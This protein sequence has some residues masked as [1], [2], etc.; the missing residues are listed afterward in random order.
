MSTLPPITPA[1]AWAHPDDEPLQKL[2]DSP[3]PVSNPLLK[4]A[5][6]RMN[7]HSS[8]DPAVVVNGT[9]KFITAGS[10]GT[11]NNETNALSV[12]NGMRLPFS[13]MDNKTSLRQR[14]KPS[15][16]MILPP[17]SS[18][19]EGYLDETIGSN[20]ENANNHS[21]GGDVVIW[22]GTPNNTPSHDSWVLVYGFSS[23][24]QYEEVLCRFDS[25]G[26][27]VSKRGG[28]LNWV[29]LHYESNLEAEKARCQQTC[30]LS[31]GCVVGVSRMDQKLSQ[32]LDWDATPA[33]VEV[34]HGGVPPTAKSGMDEDDVLRKGKAYGNGKNGSVCEKMLAFVFG[35][36]DVMQ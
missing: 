31:D 4:R 12:T 25:F 8:H 11:E 7:G 9:H 23:K 6:P 20:N 33:S 35:W 22:S 34:S 21:M 1:F 18:L 15:A 30:I 26:K 5:S 3:K 13:P 32:S 19:T 10:V 29:A 16:A 36:D 27:V 2:K 24:S 14:R 28:Q 17:K